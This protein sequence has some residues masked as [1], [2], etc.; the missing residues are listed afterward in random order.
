MTKK[1]KELL[2][3][4]EAEL[5]RQANIERRHEQL[6]KTHAARLKLLR[7]ELKNEVNKALFAAEELNEARETI[8]SRNHTINDLWLKKYD[9]EQAAKRAEIAVPFVCVFT[10]LAGAT[11]ALAA[12]YF[13]LS[14]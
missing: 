11:A 14:F 6:K 3:Q 12:A 10:V 1:E 9:L 13:P 4:V 5:T 8:K 2:A 7:A